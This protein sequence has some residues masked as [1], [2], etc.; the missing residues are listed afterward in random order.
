M[1]SNI[2]ANKKRIEDYEF[3]KTVMSRPGLDLA[4]KTHSIGTG[5]SFW[6]KQQAEWLK[7]QG[8]NVVIFDSES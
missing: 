1:K 7:K 3:L 2:K 6:I 4:M 8:Y 5:K